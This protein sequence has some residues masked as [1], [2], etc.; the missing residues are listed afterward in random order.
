MNRILTPYER[1]Q[2]I[3]HRLPESALNS[4]RDVPVEYV[5]GHVDFCGRDFIVNRE[6][7]IPRVETEELVSITVS[8]CVALSQGK[9][10]S[11]ANERHLVI[12]DIGTGSG[13]IGVSVFL[14]LCKRQLTSHIYLS[15]ISKEALSVA[16][17]NARRLIPPEN[18]QFVHFLHSDLLANYP[19][20]QLFDIVVA[21]L[22][23]VPSTRI[24]NLDDAVRDFEPTIALDGGPNGLTLIKHLIDQARGRIRTSGVL[25]LEVDETHSRDDFPDVHEFTAQLQRDSFGKHRFLVM[26]SRA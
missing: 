6:V 8:R 16:K 24:P 3:K 10:R 4:S 13:C 7:L 5:T 17:E 22:P 25:M 12:A 18:Q 21:N 15:D 19:P 1:N 26:T 14:E 20:S 23:Y 11:F 9:E 2:L